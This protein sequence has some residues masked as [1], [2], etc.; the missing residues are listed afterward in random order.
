MARPRSAVCSQ[1]KQGLKADESQG[2]GETVAKWCTWPRVALL[3]CTEGWCRGHRLWSG[4]GEPGEIA[5]L[6]QAGPAHSVQ[7]ARGERGLADEWVEKWPV[8]S[9]NVHWGK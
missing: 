7:E 4:R 6:S 9:Y 5:W 1:C 8:T 3:T 2:K